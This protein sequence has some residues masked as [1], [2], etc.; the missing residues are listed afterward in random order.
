MKKMLCAL[1]LV[2]VCM[3]M[4]A[5]VAHAD[6]P[7]CVTK[8]EYERIDN[9][10][11]KRRVHRIFDVR[12]RRSV[13]SRGGGVVVEARRYRTCRRDSAVSVAYRNGRVSGKSAVWG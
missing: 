12:G 10:Q 6:T 5:P 3:G 2:I 13:I 11:T 1:G 8:A 7:R 9:G 4:S